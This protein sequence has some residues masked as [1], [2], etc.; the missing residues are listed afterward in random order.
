MT[1]MSD[2]THYVCLT[3]TDVAGNATNVTAEFSFTVDTTAPTISSMTENGGDSSY[4]DSETLTIDV[5]MDGS[6]N[7]AAGVGLTLDNGQSATC[8]TG[9]GVTTFTCTYTIA[10]AHTN[11]TALGV[12]A[13]TGVANITDAAGNAASST[14]PTGTDALANES[15][16][17]DT[18]APGAFAFTA[19]TDGS[20][21][22]DNTPDVTWGA[23]SDTNTVTYSLTSDTVTGCGTPDQ[24]HSLTGTTQTM[25]TMSDTTH[26]V[27]LTATDVAGNTTNVTAEFSF[28]VDAVA[29]TITSMT[30]N[31][32]D[33]SYKDSE[34][35]TID[36]NMDSSVDVTA[37]VTLTLD[38]GQT[39]TCGTG[40]GI[41]TLSCTYTVATAHTNTTALDVS[42]INGVANITDVGSNPLDST[43][44]TGANALSA[45]N[46]IIDTVAPGAF[47]FTAPTDASTISDNTPDVTWGAASDTN[48]VT[49]SLT[50]DTASGCGTPDQTHSLTGTT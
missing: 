30:E 47:A 45:A 2:T 40:T 14:L 28:T 18:V 31:S 17:V 32:G 21:I 5:N 43:L 19:P 35:V 1:T 33:S 38:N 27:C 46:I 36:V 6:V 9:T 10:T 37:G 3:A 12:T 13:I 26:Y 7:V 29:P 50:S 34:T 23:A 11:T 8:G 24:T 41:T 16:I 4:K 15:I 48:T 42:S 49:Y 44:P 20:T 25:T 22:G 39:A